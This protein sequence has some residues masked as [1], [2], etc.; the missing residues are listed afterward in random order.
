MCAWYSSAPKLTS[1]VNNVTI[2][3][4]NVSLDAIA[5]DK[6]LTNS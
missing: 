2:G 1:K 6:A 5:S 3:T 4:T